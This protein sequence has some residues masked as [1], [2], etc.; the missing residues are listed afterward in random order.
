MMQYEYE[1]GLRDKTK[2]AQAAHA[3]VRATGFPSRRGKPIPH[4]RD[5]EVWAKVSK[6]KTGRP[7]PNLRGP[8][9]G[10]WR[11]GVNK[12]IWHS[13]EYQAWRKA[14][15]RRDKYTCVLCGDARGGN[16]EADHIKPRLLYPE[17]T[18]DVNNGRTLCKT[19]HRET[20]T[21]GH[22]TKV[23]YNFRIAFSVALL[24]SELIR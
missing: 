14:V 20:I 4:L 16:L 10:N 3:A 13:W 6:T 8:R 1:H 21:W 12:D 5:P 19:C 7:V 18:L 9:S 23:L 24:Y 15:F 22:N 17:L 2:I 11:G